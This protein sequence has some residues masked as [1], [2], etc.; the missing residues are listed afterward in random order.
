MKPRLA[1]PPGTGSGS[2]SGAPSRRPPPTRRPRRWRRRRRSRRAP[3]SPRSSRTRATRPSRRTSSMPRSTSR[4]SRSAPCSRSRAST[5]PAPTRP[6]RTAPRCA[7]SS[8][9]AARSTGLDALTKGWYSA[10]WSTA[11]DYELY[12]LVAGGAALLACAM[13]ALSTRSTTRVVIGEATLSATAVSSIMTLAAGRPRPFLYDTKAP[14]SVRDG[15]RLRAVIL[16]EPHLGGVRVR[17][18]LY[19]AE[20]RLHPTVGPAEGHPRR[21]PRRRRR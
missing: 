16:V 19:I 14:E 1:A 9:V 7:D 20:K 3:S 12:G 18:S 8:N 21:R 10:S 4:S 2:G 11:S 17:S 15:W 13:K 6:P 5:G